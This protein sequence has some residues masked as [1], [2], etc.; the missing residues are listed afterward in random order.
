[1]SW[2]NTSVLNTVSSVVLSHLLNCYGYSHA[3]VKTSWVVHLTTHPAS[4][5]QIDKGN[6]NE[7]SFFHF[8]SHMAYLY[9]CLL[10]C[11]HERVVDNKLRSVYV[12]AI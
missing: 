8:R 12:A 6:K 7:L 5:Q 1:M 11:L 10:G 9:L 4:N 2:V 3:E